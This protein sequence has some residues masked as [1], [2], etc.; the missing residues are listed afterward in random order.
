MSEIILPD[1]T[2]P[3][4]EGYKTAKQ[5]EVQHIKGR[6]MKYT[7]EGTEIGMDNYPVLELEMNKDYEMYARGLI[8]FNLKTA[9]EEKDYKFYIK[10][11]AVMSMIYK[12]NDSASQLAD[13]IRDDKAKKMEQLRQEAERQEFE[14][15]LLN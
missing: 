2:K 4:K 5:K 6:Y 14:D 8:Q 9:G 15:K 11:D 10:E 12:A 13:M 7:A 3:I 1:G